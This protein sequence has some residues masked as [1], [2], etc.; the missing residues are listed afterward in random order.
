LADVQ[1]LVSDSIDIVTLEGWEKSVG[2]AEILQG[3]NI[4]GTVLWST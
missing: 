2:H 3:K 1:Q 4:A